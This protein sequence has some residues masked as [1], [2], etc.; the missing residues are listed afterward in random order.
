MKTTKP[1]PKLSPLAQAKNA[2]KFY[3]KFKQQKEKIAKA[4]AEA[5][6]QLQA[7]AEANRSK[8]NEEGHYKLPGGY[9]YFGEETTIVPCDGFNMSDFVKDFPELVD[10]KF[11]V[12][13]MKTLL[14]DKAGKAKLLQNH[15]VEIKKEGVFRIVI[16]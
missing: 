4:Q 3:I 1:K 7:F 12:A 13:A 14:Q 6:A 8:F 9:L 10:K 15:C 16:K 2:L 11:K 5:A